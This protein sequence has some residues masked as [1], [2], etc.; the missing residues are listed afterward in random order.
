MTR[1]LRAAVKR[2][3][4][5]QRGGGGEGEEEAEEGDEGQLERG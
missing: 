2:W 1:R 4:L 3:T 5:W